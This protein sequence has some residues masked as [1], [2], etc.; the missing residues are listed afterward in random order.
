MVGTGGVRLPKQDW[1]RGRSGITASISAF[2]TV[3]GHGLFQRDGYQHQ[4]GAWCSP[5]DCGASPGAITRADN[6]ILVSA[7][8]PPSPSLAWGRDSMP[9]DWRAL[10]RSLPG[11]PGFRAAQRCLVAAWMAASRASHGLAALLLQGGEPIAWGSWL[12]AMAPSA[13]THWGPNLLAALAGP[14]VPSSGALQ[15]HRCIAGAQ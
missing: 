5:A 3:H 6:Q 10:A 1:G 7:E 8:H 11:G 2:F 12:S 13:W 4:P 14:G 9:W 15:Q